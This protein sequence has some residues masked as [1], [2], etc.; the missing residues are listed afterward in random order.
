VKRKHRV[1]GIILIACATPAAVASCQRHQW[2]GAGLMVL[3]IC[4]GVEWW[5]RP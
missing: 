1:A 2:V 5:W 3:L 4:G